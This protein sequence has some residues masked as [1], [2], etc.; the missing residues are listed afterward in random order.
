MKNLEFSMKELRL[1]LSLSRLANLRPFLFA[2]G[3]VSTKRLPP[4]I[5]F[6]RLYS[7]RLYRIIFTVTPLSLLVD[8]EAEDS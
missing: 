5:S 7:P 1:S 3:A 4:L 8:L 6:A 2:P